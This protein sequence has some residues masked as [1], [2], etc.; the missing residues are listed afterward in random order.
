M[1]PEG[2]LWRE[3]TRL[4][5]ALESLDVDRT[6]AMPA[7]ER[8]AR[9]NSA[10][11]T[12]RLY[13]AAET[14]AWTTMRQA[15][16]SMPPLGGRMM[17]YE[18]GPDSH[19]LN[20][21]PGDIG[22]ALSPRGQPGFLDLHPQRIF[23]GAIQTYGSTVDTANLTAVSIVG[24][25]RVNGTIA[26]EADRRSKF[27]ELGQHAPQFDFD[28]D[29]MLDPVARDYLS[30]KVEL[31]LRG[32]GNPSCAVPSARVAQAIGLPANTRPG[33]DVIRPA[34]EV[35]WQ[36]DQLYARATNRN[37]VALRAGLEAHL[38][39]N[40]RTLMPDQ[41]AAWEHALGYQMTLVWGPPGTG[42][43]HTLRA[44]I[45]GAVMDAINNGA[46]LRVLIA[47]N[48]YTAVDNILLKLQEDLRDLPGVQ[49]Q[50]QKPYSLFRVQ[51]EKRVIGLDFT[52]DYPDIVN[53]EL[54]R[55][56]PSADSVRLLGKL[57]NPDSIVI[58]GTVAQQVHNL[59][60]AGVANPH[61]AD[62]QKAWFDLTIVDEASQMDVATSTLVFSKRAD[63]G[64]C[65]LAG[66]D[67]QLPPIHQAE[68][69]EDLDNVVGSIYDFVRHERQVPYNA[70]NTSF[71]SNKTL[72]GFT[73]QA[74]YDPGLHSHSP[75]LRL[76][77]DAVPAQQPAAW[78]QGLPWS[79]DYAHILSPD[80]PA[81]ALMY[82]D[83]A[84]AQSNAFEA[85]HTASL[86]ALLRT[87]L[88]DG[89]LNE[90]DAF[91]QQIARPGAAL[92]MGDAF[93]ERGLGIVVPHR[94]Q[95][96]MIAS[97]LIAAF[98]NDAPDRIRAAV[99]T[100]ER[101]QG[102]ERDV[103][104]ASFG[105]GDPDLIAAEEEFLY[106]LRRFNVLAS[107]AR[108]KL[109][110]IVSRSVIEHLSNNS[111][112]LADSLLL[113]RY[114]EQFCVRAPHQGGGAPWELRWR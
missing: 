48:T 21:R 57:D 23:Q 102:Q 39:M 89:L 100:V 47:A 24:I 109:I 19:D 40:T 79:P 70:L 28:E 36:A 51:S 29:V 63:A 59:A 84:S 25:D 2:Y 77:L 10:L 114:A 26:L 98:P 91:G 112:V 71:R 6:R 110:V 38:W 4:N 54:N 65:V 45:M 90:I 96:S 99:D 76:N 103:I 11:L 41:W 8:E 78:A 94:A 68:A 37:L 86:A 75:N 31:T 18:M 113:K 60:L 14:A 49:T 44:I 67:L 15:S 80:R 83:R 73:R 107:R 43:S 93:W 30:E 61:A 50:G 104:V 105:L 13:G 5:N 34:A 46:P 1:S 106:S 81:V 66:D 82:T 69:P 111:D 27:A 87:H 101:F 52:V 12:R 9:F 56:N 64:A 22:Y 42:K 20:A 74:G 35:L 58:V 7:H 62:T 55:R 97:R 17:I 92:Y 95:M 16:P 72:I 32:I 33:H 53:V 3:F 108:A 85:G 88:R